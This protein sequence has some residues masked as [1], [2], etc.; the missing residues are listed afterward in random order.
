MK[1]KTVAATTLAACLAAANA[2]G[3][4]YMIPEQ[5]PSSIGLAGAYIAAARGADSSFHNPANMDRA[6]GSGAGEID[7]T[8]INL[9]SLDY[10][11]AADPSRNSG[12]KTEHFFLPQAYAVSPGLGRDGRLRVGA[13]LTYPAGLSKRWDSPFARATTEE[14]TLRVTE[15]TPSVSY[16]F[17][18]LLSM[19]AGVRTIYAKGVVKSYA[20]LSSA[21]AP[22]TFLSR[23]MKGDGTDFGYILAATLR[24][25]ERLSVAATYR[26]EVDIKLKGDAVLLS[27]LPASFGGTYTGGGEVNL[28]IP[29]VF[30]LA[31]AYD[32][33]ATTVELVWERTKWSTFEYLDFNYDRDLTATPLRNFDLPVKKSWSDTDAFRLGITHRINDRL[34]AT[35]GVARVEAPVPEQTLGFE[36]P[37]ASTNLYSLGTA[38]KLE[39]MELACGY[40]YVDMDDRT[41]TGNDYGINGTFSNHTAHL[42]SLAARFTLS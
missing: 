18:D 27:N 7:F 20:Q 10:T 33:G 28:P 40:M 12:S 30:N 36:L 22:L 6:P 38:W 1:R 17:S 31:A 11:D 34:T 16:K 13:S 39:R 14:F 19:A 29:E 9:P 32:L 41:V 25:A 5:S 3:S 23:D 35:I 15:F 2:M 42:F 26:S 4:G 8:Y 24:P 21:Y 37:D